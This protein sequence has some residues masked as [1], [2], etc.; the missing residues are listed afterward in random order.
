MSRVTLEE[1]REHLRLLHDEDD[2]SVQVYLDAAED[3]LKGFDVIY[4][5]PLQPA[6][7]A[8][9]LL[10]VGHLYENREA[11]TAERLQPL[12]HGVDALISQHRTF[13]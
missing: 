5:T 2:T 9:I 6:V 7:R 1:A 4:K 10:V 13:Q 8:A 3:Y 11:L 12:R